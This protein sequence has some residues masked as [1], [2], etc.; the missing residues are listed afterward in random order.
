M[1]QVDIERAYQTGPDLPDIIRSEAGR[2]LVKHC[3]ETHTG[4]RSGG[5]ESW[6]RR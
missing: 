6:F 3:M 1:V 4:P 2:A 5:S